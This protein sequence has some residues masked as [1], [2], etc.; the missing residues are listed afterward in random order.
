MDTLLAA[1]RLIHKAIR[2]FGP[3]RALAIL[4]RHTMPCAWLICAMCV[5]A[6]GYDLSRGRRLDAFLWIAM[7]ALSFTALWMNSTAQTGTHWN[8]A[9]AVAA[10]VVDLWV[11]GRSLRERFYNGPR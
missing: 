4:A 8:A 3:A 10:V 9:F 11:L 1:A 7:A 5:C 2:R 6:G